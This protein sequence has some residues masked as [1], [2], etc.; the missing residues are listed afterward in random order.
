MNDEVRQI[1]LPSGRT[2]SIRRG[3]G[4]DLMRAHRAAAGNPEPLAISF[5][6]VAEL[7]E[8]EG[9][10]I[11]YEDML[12]MDLDDVLALQGEV[13]GGDGGANFPPPAGPPPADFPDQV[14]SPDSSNSDSDTQS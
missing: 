6:L 7:A 10:P 13:I 12:A 14:Q 3:K 9:K 11:V 5:A 4:R 1:T 2:A 8:I